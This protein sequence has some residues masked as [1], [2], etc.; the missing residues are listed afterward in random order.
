MSTS[1]NSDEEQQEQLVVSGPP[2]PIP[3]DAD[4][5][6]SGVGSNTEHGTDNK[7]E[8]AAE[9]SADAG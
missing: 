8:G 2:V 1:P 9:D 7:T 4:T 3:V 6:A 5:L